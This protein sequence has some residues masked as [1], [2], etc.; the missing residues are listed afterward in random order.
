[1]ELA[2]EDREDEFKG[3]TPES[4]GH[5]ENRAMRKSVKIFLS[6]Y[7]VIGRQLKGLDTKPPYVHA[8]LK[9]DNYIE[10]PKV[11]EQLKPFEPF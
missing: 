6:H 3:S 2:E 5:A 11:P 7:W 10:P 8:K 9:H 4:K 1:M